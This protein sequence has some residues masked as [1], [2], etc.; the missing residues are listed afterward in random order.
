MTTVDVDAS[1]IT[2]FYTFHEVFKD[3]LGFID[4]YGNNMNAWIDC[5][6]DIHEDTGMSNILLP[7]SEPLTLKINSSSTVKK[8]CPE[9]LEALASCTGHVNVHLYERNLAPIYLLFA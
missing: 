5:M 3:T 6:R 2:D 1:K 8:A 4:G 9:V 7:E